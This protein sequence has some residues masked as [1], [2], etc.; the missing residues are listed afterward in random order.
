MMNRWECKTA[1]INKNYGIVIFNRNGYFH[2][3]NISYQSKAD[4]IINVCLWV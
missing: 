3:D 1:A 4:K 2:K